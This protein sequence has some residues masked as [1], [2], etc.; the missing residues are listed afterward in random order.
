MVLVFIDLPK[1]NISSFWSKSRFEPR[2]PGSHLISII[3]TPPSHITASH[4]NMQLQFFAKIIPQI[5][6][7]FF[8]FHIKI[9]MMEVVNIICSRIE[10]NILYHP[11]TPSKNIYSRFTCYVFYFFY[12]L[13][14]NFRFLYFLLCRIKENKIIQA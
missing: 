10:L 7:V 6:I 11:P 13:K 2:S 3:V 14:F 8:L 12:A 1:F 4:S 9:K 5:I